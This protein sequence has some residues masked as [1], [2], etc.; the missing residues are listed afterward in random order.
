MYNR[1]SDNESIGTANFSDYSEVLFIERYKYYIEEYAMYM[2][3]TSLSDVFHSCGV[4]Q[5]FHCIYNKP[6]C[7]VAFVCLLP[8]PSGLFD[9]TRL[10]IMSLCD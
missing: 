6:F 9:I 8:L 10:F 2:G 4:Q 5:R 3:I 7:A 1:T